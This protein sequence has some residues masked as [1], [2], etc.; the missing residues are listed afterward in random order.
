MSVGLLTIFAA[1]LCFG[2]GVWWAK[3]IGWL[4]GVAA[5][6]CRFVWLVPLIWSLTP[7]T[8]TESLP[9]VM[10]QQPIHI[11]LDDSLSM[12]G[13]RAASALNAEVQK[14]L[15]DI[16]EICLRFGCLPK[17]DRLSEMRSETAKGF[18]PLSA[19]LEPW[20][21][22]IGSEPWM[23]LSDGAD[24]RP[25]RVWDERLRGRGAKVLSRQQGAIVSFGKPA[26][27]GF[28]LDD[29]RVP[30]FAFEGRTTKVDAGVSRASTVGVET[31]QIQVAVDGQAVSSA[32]A[33]FADGASEAR[34]ELAFAS[35][36]RGP[37]LITVKSLP[38][39][40]EKDI[41]DNEWN[42]AL[43]V[44]PNTI[45]VLHLLGSPS[46]DGRFLRRYLKAEPKFDLI[47]FFILRD[48]WDSQQ[49]SERELSLIPFPVERL[50]KE[51]LPSF[52]VLVIQNFTMQQFLQPEYQA[53]LV[54]FVLDGGGLL[55][56]GGP[57]GLTQGDMVNSPIGEILPFTV[58]GAANQ[59]NLMIP[60][61][62]DRHVGSTFDPQ[63]K[64]SVTLAEPDAQK[65][66]LA[67][68]YDDWEKMSHRLTNIKSL[69]GLHRMG[70]FK[71]KENAVTPLLN[72]K[73]ENGSTVPLAVASYPGKGRAI[74]LFTDSL[75]RLG[76]NEDNDRS[77][78]DYNEF[79]DGAMTWLMRNDRRP[80]LIAK[81]FK[82][83]RTDD[84]QSVLWQARISGP[85][86]RYVGAKGGEWSIA[87]CGQSVPSDRS[88]AEQQSSEEWL[89][90][91]VVSGSGNLGT[92]CSLKIVGQHPAFGSV[93]ASALAVFSETLKDVDMS[94]S[95]RKLRQLAEVTESLLIGADEDRSRLI[96]EWL[97]V[98]TGEENQAL[99]SR[100]KTIRDFY[101]P[102]RQPWIW[103]VFLFI[104]AEVLIRRW[105]LLVG[106]KAGQV[107]EGDLDT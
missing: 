29:V 11:L 77:R 2:L 57:R 45:G 59:D 15:D 10:I 87:V 28:W 48:P 104:P 101:W 50:F 9:S 98:W 56:I 12:R 43:E 81:D 89:L 22:K 18:T 66:S 85:A 4:R 76:M 24:W 1:V 40:D 49:V 105:H 38:V 55:F 21:F 31:V 39:S 67:N 86:A 64:F 30:S 36:V 52:R 13:G 93:T 42:S 90:S 96:G 83:E 71:F 35:P 37:H 34:T 41:W 58:E 46:W 25:S 68:V 79:L 69:Q 54:K 73:L 7:E 27:P 32:N 5:A 26:V 3:Q 47:S 75:W 94:P 92:L 19:A 72:A 62:G 78:F 51:E 106:H 84:E 102:Q 74:W 17:I 60:G 8:I 99:P 61:F 53:N 95:P 107:S 103:L 63:T 91:G 33:V 6:T 97:R 100:F 65:R 20:L 88:Q 80:S 44:L 82:V 14:T 16:Q 70:A 23:V